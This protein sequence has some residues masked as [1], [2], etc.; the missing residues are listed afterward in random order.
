MKNETIGDLQMV[1]ISVG[2]GSG[3]KVFQSLL[4]SHQEVLMIPGYA[5]MYFYPFWHKYLKNDKLKTWETVINKLIKV[6]GSVFDTAINPGSES[7][8]NLGKNHNKTLTI[9]IPKFKNAFTDIVNGKEITSKKCLIAFHCAYA[10]AADISLDRVKIIIYPIHVHFYAKKYL[11]K[12]FP[13]LKIIA[14][15]RDPRANISR[16]VVNSIQRPNERWLRESDEILM[17]P[18]YYRQAMYPITNGLDSFVPI[19][20]DN[21]RVFLHEDLVTRLEDVMHKTAV[22]LGIKYS[23]CMLKPTW[24]GVVW[25]TTYYDFDSTKH[26]VN[27]TVL[28]KDWEKAESKSEMFVIEGVSAGVLRKYYKGNAYYDEDNILSIVKLFVF[29]LIVTKIEQRHIR[30]TFKVKKYFN[31]LINEVRNIEKLKPYDHN[32]FY[33]L[34]WTNEEINFGR[35]KMYEYFLLNNVSF[36]PIKIRKFF[37]KTLYFIG[38]TIFYIKSIVFLPVNYFLKL[39]MIYLS[40][41]RRF[42]DN[43]CLPEKL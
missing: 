23:L 4:D 29:S 7:L 18:R 11:Y 8:N 1:A 43:S 12:D 41:Y 33:A 36:L 24:R 40:L 37:A 26:A 17:R 27:P 31:T 39:K 21:I 15:V 22:F 38:Q 10:R 16:R 19:N 5:L 34:K 20:M 32:L 28:S 35:I 6:F 30:N 9:D 25:N 2:N 3:T 13:D 42:S 14:S